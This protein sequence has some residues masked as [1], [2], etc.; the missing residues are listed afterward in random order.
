MSH[1]QHKRTLYRLAAILTLCAGLCTSAGESASAFTGFCPAPAA[2]Q[3]TEGSDMR[4]AQRDAFAP[5]KLIRQDPAL[6]NGC[7]VTSLAMVLTAAGYPIDYV[8][9][10]NDHLPQA[11][12]TEENGVRHSASPEDAYVGDAAA[13]PGGWYCFE[14]PLMQAGNE[15]ITE[16]DNNA[17]MQDLRGI[18]RDSLLAYAAVEIPVICWVTIDYATPNHFLDYSWILPD[19]NEYNPYSNLHCVVVTGVENGFF[20]IADPLNGWQ[21]VKK[22]V[23][24]QSFEAM[25]Q[26]A[27]TLDPSAVG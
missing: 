20:R 22:D 23:F 7:E 2:A 10:Y 8:A 18:D 16:N 4:L 25:G 6:P 13:A 27:V 3:T 5:V 11:D 15:W 12:I 14:Q 21:F 24:W 26:R 9:L 17:R 19:D 1:V